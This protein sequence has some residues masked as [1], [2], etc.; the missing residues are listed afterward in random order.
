MIKSDKSVNVW[1]AGIMI[2]ILM[3]SNKVLI[4]PSLLFERAKFEAV[5]V[6]VILSFL[7]MGLLYLFYR[8]KN[9]YPTESFLFIVKEH[10]G[11]FVMVVVCVFF[12]LFFLSKIVLS[13]NIT[14]I[15]FKTVLYKD[16]NNFLFLICFLPIINHLAC[17]GLR[18]M[19]RTM[20]L[21]FP[22][23]LA[24]ICFCVLVGGFGINSKPLLFQGE[25][26]EVFV[27]TLKHISGFGDMIFLF[28][29]MNKIKVKKGQ[30][31]V[32]FSL[33]ALAL[34]LVFAVT[35]IFML[36]FTYTAYMHPF[37]LFEIM[38]YVKEF[39]GTGRIDILSMICIIIL[40]YFQMAIYLKSFMTAFNAIFY[41]INKIYS[42]LTFNLFFVFLVNYVV[43][44]L[45]IAVYYGET[46]LPYVSL[47][48]FVLIPILSLLLEILR[49]RRAKT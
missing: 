20:Q 29:F 30:W 27:E 12:M 11:K 13:Y 1:Q 7:E 34:V 39:G 24:L 40:T 36:S 26:G 28:L 32:L 22:V 18:V 17:C 15:F 48:S 31:K 21:F 8:L 16:N 47:F 46:I 23:V 5:F 38:N 45:E 37:A 35:L 43:L 42:V 41:K 25:I 2:F 49:R 6:I 14:Y 4:L 9:K 44:N 3:F 10:L 33:S 19:G